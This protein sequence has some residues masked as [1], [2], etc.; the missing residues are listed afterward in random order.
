MNSDRDIGL[1]KI[2]LQS[3]V[4]LIYFH[5]TIPV[6]AVP[7]MKDWICNVSKLI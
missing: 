1:E 3:E 2:S 6:S 4:I 5:F 7:L